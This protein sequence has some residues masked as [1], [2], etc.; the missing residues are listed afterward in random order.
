[1][2]KNINLVPKELFLTKGVG[3]HID[4][5]TS[6]EEALR[7]AGI[8]NQNLVTVSSIFPP[9]CKMISREK[10]LKKLQPGSITFCVMARCDTNEHGRLLSSSVG[11][12]LP[13]DKKRWGYLSEVHGFGMT[14]AMC[15][16]QAEDTAAHMLGTTL[17]IE[18]DPEIAWSEK[19]QVYRSTGLI[20]RTSEITQSA[21]GKRGLWCTTLA[22]AVFILG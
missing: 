10:G 21:K 17:G 6:F 19:E 9:G 4:R 3:Y 22:A 7:S 20:I 1:M 11:I 13:K 18:V 15:G 14:K 5:L 12:A 16:E 2:N 8:A